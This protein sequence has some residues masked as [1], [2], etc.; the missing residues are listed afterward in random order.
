MIIY[1]LLYIKDDLCAKFT[2]I[3]YLKK[4]LWTITIAVYNDW[5]KKFVISD[6]VLFGYILE[7]LQYCSNEIMNTY[8]RIEK[9]PNNL[10]FLQEKKEQ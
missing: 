3:K 5:S 6:Y 1:F 10:H 2:Q 9:N 8:C 7:I 4:G